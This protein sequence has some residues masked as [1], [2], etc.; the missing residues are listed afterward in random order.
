M[1][2]P[3]EGPIEIRLV[4]EPDVTGQRA[5]GAMGETR[6]GHHTMRARKVLVSDKL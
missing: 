4:A 2:P 5:D 6:V 3:S 1:I